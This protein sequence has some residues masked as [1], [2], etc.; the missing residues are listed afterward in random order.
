[1]VEREDPSQAAPEDSPDQ[2]VD[3]LGR[4]TT[5]DTRSHDAK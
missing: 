3:R 1:M 4:K 2:A 5:D